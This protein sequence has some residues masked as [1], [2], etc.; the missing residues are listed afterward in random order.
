M[1]DAALTR[2][3]HDDRTRGIAASER[4]G[5]YGMHGNLWEWTADAYRPDADPGRGP[6]A[7]D[8]IQRAVGDEARTLRGGDWY[9]SASHSRSAVRDEVRCPKNPGGPSAVRPTIR[10]ADTDPRAAKL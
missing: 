3:S 8:P 5:L 7:V 4:L 10:S 9:K 1:G 6:L 2:V